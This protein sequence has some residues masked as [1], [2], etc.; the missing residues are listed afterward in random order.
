MKASW[1]LSASYEKPDEKP[2]WWRGKE[3]GNVGLGLV[4]YSLTPRYVTKLNYFNLAYNRKVRSSVP[5]FR[6]LC[7]SNKIFTIFQQSKHGFSYKLVTETSMN[8]SRFLVFCDSCSSPPVTV[9]HASPRSSLYYFS[10][11]LHPPSLTKLT[12]TE[13]CC[14]H[15]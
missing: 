5:W 14:I 7:P 13:Y 3:P 8:I 11:P 1:L 10:F 2:L 12:R 6:V 4:Q 9:I 15:D